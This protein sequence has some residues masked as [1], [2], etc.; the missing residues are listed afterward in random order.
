M[1][2]T[3]T[4]PSLFE[5]RKATLDAHPMSEKTQ[6]P[7]CKKPPDFHIG[8]P[9]PPDILLGK[10]RNISAATSR[11]NAF[12][13]WR[14]IMIPKNSIKVNRN[15]EKNAKTYKLHQVDLHAI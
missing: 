3:D 4:L 13:W 9:A 14:S 10:T 15:I 6:P 7:D 12:P 8:S 11:F 1:P 5:E 2:K